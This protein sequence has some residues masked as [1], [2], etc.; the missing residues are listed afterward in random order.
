MQKLLPHVHGHTAHVFSQTC[1]CRQSHAGVHMQR[2]IQT[3]PAAVYANKLTQIVTCKH[4]HADCSVQTSACRL[5]L[6]CGTCKQLCTDGAC[7]ATCPNVCDPRNP[8]LVNTGVHPRQQCAKGIC[9]HVLAEPATTAT[10]R[11][12]VIQSG[13]CRGGFVQHPSFS[14]RH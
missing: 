12:P 5:P 11:V 10:T 9:N 13:R 6:A 14:E 2:H 3:A 4:P 8:K 7:T 1:A